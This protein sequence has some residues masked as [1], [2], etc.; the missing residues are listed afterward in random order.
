[1]Q[2]DQANLLD[3]EPKILVFSGGSGVN[4]LVSSFQAISPLS[5]YVLPISDNGG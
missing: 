2:I 5:T 4:D 1:M 3:F